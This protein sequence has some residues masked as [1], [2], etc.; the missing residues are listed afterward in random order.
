[1]GNAPKS[2]KSNYSLQFLISFSFQSKIGLEFRSHW[3]TEESIFEGKERKILSF[4]VVN[5][6][7]K[8]NQGFIYS[9]KFLHKSVF[10]ILFGFLILNANIG[11]S[12]W[13]LQGNRSP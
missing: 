6:G 7:L 11:I 5:N 13:K 2:S 12:L 9:P 4:S 10:P 8:R 1:M 3:D